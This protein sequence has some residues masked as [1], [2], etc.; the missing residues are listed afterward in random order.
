MVTDVTDASASRGW[1]A[2]RTSPHVTDTCAS[3][4]WRTWRTWPHVTD[5][6]SRHGAFTLKLQ[7]GALG[8][9]EAS[10]DGEASTVLLLATLRKTRHRQAG[11]SSPAAGLSRRVAWQGRRDSNHRS[12]R[13]TSAGGAPEASC[14]GDEGGDERHWAWRRQRERHHQ[15]GEAPRTA[16]AARRGCSECTGGTTRDDCAP[17]A[18]QSLSGQ[19]LSGQSLSGQSLSGQSVF[20]RS[21]NGI[22]DLEPLYKHESISQ[23]IAQLWQ[24]MNDCPELFPPD[25]PGM[26]VPAA[27][28][29][30]ATATPS[31]SMPLP[32]SHLLGLA[33]HTGNAHGRGEAHLRAPCAG[34]PRPARADRRPLL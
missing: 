21:C 23:I 5:A 15:H 11:W 10:T 14:G 1:R 22:G 12:F 6:R 30:A 31:P 16:G 25:D 20:V 29:R 19:S 13:H 32:R 18:S 9:P 33:V 3:P 4:G 34:R 27:A 26:K 8:A 7:A 28:A 24:I 2:W 17:G